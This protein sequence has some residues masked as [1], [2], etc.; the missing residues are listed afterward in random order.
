[1]VGNSNGFGIVIVLLVVAGILFFGS[2]NNVFSVVS[3]DELVI[4]APFNLDFGHWLNNEPVLLQNQDGDFSFTEGDIPVPDLS[5]TNLDLS[6]QSA[7]SSSVT[8]FQDGYILYLN[9][10]LYSRQVGSGSERRE[11]VNGIPMVVTVPETPF[12]DDWISAK[13]LDGWSFPTT[14]TGS[15]LGGRNVYEGIYGVRTINEGSGGAVTSNTVSF[16]H[17]FGVIDVTSNPCLLEAGEFIAVESFG[18]EQS[19]DALSFTFPVNQFCSVHPPI[20]I[21]A[22]SMPISSNVDNGILSTLE[23]GGVVSVPNGVIHS[24]FYT[25]LIS[26]TNLTSECGVDETFNLASSGCESLTGFVAPCNVPG[27]FFDNNTNTCSQQQTTN[28]EVA[29]SGGGGG[30]GGSGVIRIEPDV[31]VVVTPDLTEG[32]TS[33]DNLVGLIIVIGIIGLIFFNRRKK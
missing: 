28:V 12:S 5:L 7:G 29:S 18:E 2:Q 16:R 1:M 10:R 27:S 13:N 8:L 6:E 21:D 32:F 9:G 4:V 30:G 26:D 3:P 14:T 20:V 23:N 33:G 11:V 22:D 19:Y 25:F 17:F 15:L 31:P 24:V